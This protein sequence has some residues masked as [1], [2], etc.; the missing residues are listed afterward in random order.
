MLLVDIW[1]I[2]N[3]R[4][5]R[6]SETY[7]VPAH[8]AGYLALQPGTPYSIL[9]L[10]P[11]LDAISPSRHLSHSSPVPVT[12]RRTTTRKPKATLVLIYIPNASGSLGVVDEPDTLKS[13][14]RHAP[15]PP[16]QLSDSSCRLD[17]GLRRPGAGADALHQRPT[18]AYWYHTRIT[19]TSWTRVAELLAPNRHN[20]QPKLWACGCVDV[21]RESQPSHP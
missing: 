16:P 5:P 4:R 3:R 8:R 12:R 19:T 10:R 13:G 6:C 15:V 7:F 9:C 14:L 1:E 20:D 2:N 21:W 11:R 17:S 18:P